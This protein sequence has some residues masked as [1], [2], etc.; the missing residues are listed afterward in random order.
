MATNES[1]MRKY[2]T[3]RPWRSAQSVSCGTSIATMGVLLRNADAPAEGTSRRASDPLRLVPSPS[4]QET[5]G[6]N[7]PVFSTARATT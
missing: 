3:E 1:G 7:A 2:D 6:C 4:T 5:I